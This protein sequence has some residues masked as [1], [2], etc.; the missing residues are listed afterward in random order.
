M[1]DTV[2]RLET[3]TWRALGTGVRLVVRGRNLERAQSAVVD[4]LDRVDR[5]YSRFRGDSEITA[6]NAAAEVAVLPPMS[7]G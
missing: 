6:L 5:A 4:V 7:G 2:D 3:A 1:T